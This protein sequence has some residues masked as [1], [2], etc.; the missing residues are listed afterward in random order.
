MLNELR[1]YADLVSLGSYVVVYDTIVELSPADYYE[2]RPWNKGNSPM[3][4]VYQFLTETKDFE[5]DESIP[6]KL[7]ITVAPD[8]FLRRIK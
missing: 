8:G 2:D 3:T 5:I 1:A 4:A 6:N 7:L